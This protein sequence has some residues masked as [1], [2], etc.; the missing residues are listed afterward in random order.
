MK[1]INVLL[2]LLAIVISCQFAFSQEIDSMKILPSS[3]STYDSVMFATF[4]EPF[5]GDCS[6][7][8][9]IDSTG[10]NKIYISGK[11]DSNGKCLTDGAN[12]TINLG[13]LPVGVYTIY[14]S[15][16]DTYGF[17]VTDVL[18]MEFNVSQYTGL[19]NLEQKKKNNAY[20]N[21]C[22]SYLTISNP[23]AISELKFIQLF[24]STGQQLI[25]KHIY[26]FDSE[27]TI[28]MSSYDIG[29][30]FLISNDKILNIKVIKE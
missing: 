17:I 2:G 27:I 12:D 11:Y 4:S 14:L 30:Y 21:P 9:K 15:F 7:V 6:Y 20:P 10:S 5:S 18:T 29:L 13:K 25:E 23:S 24:N 28:D 19:N 16:I 26:N 3:P 1:S 22:N 8:L